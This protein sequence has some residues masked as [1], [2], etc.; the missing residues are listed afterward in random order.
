MDGIVKSKKDIDSLLKNA[1]SV[2][3]KKK[4]ETEISIVILLT[5]L[6]FRDSK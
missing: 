2:K 6:K 5:V 3:L 1:K 4:R